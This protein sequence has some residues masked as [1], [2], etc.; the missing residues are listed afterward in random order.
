MN[1]SFQRGS[2]LAR[3]PA[4]VAAASSLASEFRL[5]FDFNR[6]RLRTA[7]V[8]NWRSL[9]HSLLARNSSYTRAENWQAVRSAQMVSSGA[10]AQSSRRSVRLPV[11]SHAVRTLRL[12]R[13]LRRPAPSTAA[14]VA[15]AH[16]LATGETQR[17]RADLTNG[18]WA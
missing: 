9:G 14:H 15:D 17:S 7:N 2:C 1:H 13:R 3:R 4:R 12:D 5:G 8:Y 18:R 10:M 16:W 11:A 6:R